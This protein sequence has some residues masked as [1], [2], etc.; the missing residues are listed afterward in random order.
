MHG[1][2]RHDGIESNQ[3]TL[4]MH[5]D[6][7]AHGNCLVDALIQECRACRQHIGLCSHAQDGGLAQ[8]G[9]QG[10]DFHFLTH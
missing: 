2:Q 6:G 9:G 10:R 1:T 4:W 3:A 5:H 8:N 7:R